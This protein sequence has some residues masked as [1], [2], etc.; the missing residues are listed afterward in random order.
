MRWRWHKAPGCHFGTEGGS[1]G[2]SLAC[3]LARTILLACRVKNVSHSTLDGTGLMAE[4]LRCPAVASGDVSL[5][6]SLD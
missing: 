1:A 4:Q 5:S 2:L 6:L 3:G